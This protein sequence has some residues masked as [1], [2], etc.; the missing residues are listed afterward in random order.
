MFQ[1]IRPDDAMPFAP[2][3]S[4]EIEGRGGAG[5]RVPVRRMFMEQA[6]SVAHVGAFRSPEVRSAA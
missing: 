4:G 1:R 3:A 2:E 5:A 6:W